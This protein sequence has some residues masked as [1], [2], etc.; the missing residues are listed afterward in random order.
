M[1]AASRIF[2]LYV[3]VYKQTL[4]QQ[5]FTTYFLQIYDLFFKFL[6]VR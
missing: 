1:K 3:L 2:E 5:N 6:V 4:I